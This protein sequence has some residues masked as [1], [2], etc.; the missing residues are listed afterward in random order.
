MP[1]GSEQ[2]AQ[3]AS[4]KINKS[5]AAFIADSLFYTMNRLQ[6]GPLEILVLVDDNRTKCKTKIQK[7]TAKNTFSACVCRCIEQ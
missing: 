6:R 5:A 3:P 2:P 1:N 4:G 7:N